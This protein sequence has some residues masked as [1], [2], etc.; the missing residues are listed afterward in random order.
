MSEAVSNEDI[1][2]IIDKNQIIVKRK[3]ATKRRI[4]RFISKRLLH[5]AFPIVKA[6]AT[7]PMAFRSMS[8]LLRREL[9]HVD[10][11]SVEPPST[12]LC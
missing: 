1:S 6:S 4:D 12:V 11:D 7:D 2:L 3:V 8:F 9:T 5:R 10:N